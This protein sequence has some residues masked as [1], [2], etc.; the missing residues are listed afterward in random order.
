MWYNVKYR[1]K[2]TLGTWLQTENHNTLDYRHSTTA[3][4]ATDKAPQ[5][6]WLQT[7]HHSTLG[8]GHSTTAHLTADTAPQHT[9]LQ[10]QHHSTLG[11]RHSTTA[12]LATD[13]APQHRACVQHKRCSRLAQW[14]WQVQ[15]KH[16]GVLINQ[17][18][19]HTIKRVYKCG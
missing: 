9:R 15:P 3:H 6:T 4:S 18:I 14:Q 2:L 17:L 12:H 7:Q 19:C 5:H 13:T 1:T 16:V 10:T 11:Y 8:Y